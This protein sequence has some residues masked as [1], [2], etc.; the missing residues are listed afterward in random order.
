[1]LLSDVDAIVLCLLSSSLS[2]VVTD[3]WHAY[4]GGGL[5]VNDKLWRDGARISLLPGF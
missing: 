5:L 4:L 1:M 2:D 3:G